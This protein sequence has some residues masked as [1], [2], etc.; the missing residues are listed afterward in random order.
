MM[1]AR[2]KY[3]KYIFNLVWVLTVNICEAKRK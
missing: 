3:L 1:S 2:L